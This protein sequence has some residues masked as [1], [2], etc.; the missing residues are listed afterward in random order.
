MSKEEVIDN[1]GTIARSGTKQFLSSLEKS[2]STD[3]QLIGQFG[4][5]FYSVFLVAE[6][7]ELTT[8]RAGS[9][10]I[11]GVRWISDGS[12]E[13]TIEEFGLDH[14]GTQITLHLK[15]DDNEFPHM[16]NNPIKIHKGN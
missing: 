6:Q 1:I 9:A 5:G 11:D 15:T 7:V 16:S 13:Y 2:G 10:K 3:S 14:H 8:R 4:V 12:G